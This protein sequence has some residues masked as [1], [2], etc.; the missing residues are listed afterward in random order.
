MLGIT[1]NIILCRNKVSRKSFKMLF[2][3]ITA[4]DR[5]QHTTVSHNLELITNMEIEETTDPDSVSSYTSLFC[6]LL[7]CDSINL[8]NSILTPPIGGFP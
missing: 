2:K 5:K 1:N 6:G 7:H 3:D 4:M 8:S